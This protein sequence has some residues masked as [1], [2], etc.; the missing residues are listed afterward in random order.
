METQITDNKTILSK[1]K[2]KIPKSTYLQNNWQL[3]VMLILPLACLITFK[4]LPMLGTAVAFKDYNIFQGIWDSEWI[5]F[6]HF[7]EAF[8]SAEFWY[9]IQNTLILNLG[10]L[11][12][13]F[14][15][16]IILAIF[17]N[18]LNGN[19]VKKTSQVIMYLPHFLSWVIISGIVQ[20]IFSGGGL[21]NQLLGNFG[22]APIAFLSNPSHWR[23]VYWFTGIWQSAGYGL[24]IYLAALTSIDPSL[25]EASYIDGA[26]R[27]KRIWYVTLPQLR[28]TISMML[29]MSLGK[30]M[31]IS[32]DRP[33]LLGNLLVKDASNVI[34]THVYSLGL[35]SGRFDFA[36]AIGLFQSVI[37]V[38]L[39]LIV[40]ALAKK[41]G[42]EGIL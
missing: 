7:R 10:D 4:Y 27:F 2:N 24:I 1:Q 18:E 42:E 5:G 28:P 16:P 37:G 26:G 12:L 41:F 21:I 30:V 22:V 14:P 13:G 35:Q 8:S 39:I 19:K 20:Q 29:I 40:N 3:Y 34:S 32:F 25:Y 23:F 17:L 11:L 31:A 9:A 38:I 6:S 33:Y 36:T 15:I